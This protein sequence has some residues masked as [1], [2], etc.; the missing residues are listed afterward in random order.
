MR[1]TAEDQT[2][3]L[4]FRASASRA[5]L[6]CLSAERLSAQATAKLTTM[7]RT[8][9]KNDQGLTATLASWKK[10]RSKASQAI[11]TVVS[12]SRSV[13][14]RAERFSTLPWP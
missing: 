4:W 6:E 1:T 7:E 3:A 14:K 9:T 2:S 10:S 8:M 5:W 11:Q 12:R 13:S